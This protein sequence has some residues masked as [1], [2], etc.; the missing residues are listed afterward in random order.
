M[1]VQI[2]ERGMNVL[3]NREL[4]QK[5]IKS[6]I[7]SKDRFD[8]G[9]AV[10]VEGENISVQTVISSTEHSPERNRKKCERVS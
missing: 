3:D 5:V 7:D 9:Q 10:K 8:A 2:S 1:L 6:I 4:A